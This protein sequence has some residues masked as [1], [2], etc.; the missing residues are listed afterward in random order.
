MLVS[1]CSGPGVCE[2]LLCVSGGVVKGG[3]QCVE[4]IWQAVCST[5]GTGVT[6]VV[7]DVLQ[8]LPH[9]S[10]WNRNRPA[11]Q[12]YSTSDQADM[13]SCSSNC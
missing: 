4:V 8:A 9:A 3:V 2:A 5:D 11:C 13:V 10:P 1:R 6:P 7:C 12:C